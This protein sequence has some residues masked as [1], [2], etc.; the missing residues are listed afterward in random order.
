LRWLFNDRPLQWSALTQRSAEANA[1]HTAKNHD[2]VAPP[3]RPR[4]FRPHAINRLKEARMDL[5]RVA[6]AIVAILCLLCTPAIAQEARGTVQGRVLDS[7]G[8]AVPGATVEVVNV[9]TGVVTAT[10]TNGEGSYRV[11]FLIPGKYRVTVSLTGF[12][13]FLSEDFTV[14]VSDVLTV[15]AAL[16]V[17]AITD[18]VT[19]TASTVTVDRATAEL[20]QVVDARRIE[21]LPIRE[22]S[23]VE[24]VVLAP[25]VTVTT[26]LRSRKAAFNNGLSQFSTDGVGE[27]KN[28]FTIDGVSNVA[29]DRVAYS[30]PSASVEEFKIHTSSYDA[31]I[32]NT[33][34]SVVNLVTKS[35]TNTLR[36]QAYEWFRGAALD[37]E[38]FFDKRAGRPKRDYNDNRFGG[39]IGGPIRSNR[40]FYFG[41][42]EGNVWQGPQPQILTVPTAKMR[43]GDFSDLLALGPQYQLY[44][45]FTTKPHP[46]QAG[47]FI[48]DPFV[49][50]MIP[51]SLI[52]PVAKKI[53]EFFPLPNQPGLSDGQQNF[54]NPTAVA[55]ETYYTATGRVDHNISAK[56]RI[57]GRFSWD[58]WEEEKDDRFDNVAT[59]IFLNRKNR[60]LGLD[61][62]YTFRNNLLLNVRGG[63]TRQLFPERRR[64]QG[65]DL[66]SLGF[67]PQLLSLVP[68]GLSA[69]PFINF[70]N[71][72]DFGV[73]ESG[74]G[75]FTTDVYS[76]TG[77]LMW[78]LG[79]HSTKFGTEYR[80]YIED[81]SRF[82]NAVS[83]QLNFSTTWV[84]GPL[85]NSAAAPFGQDFASFLLGLPT[86]GTMSRAA[87]YTEKSSVLS[88]YAHDDWRV[89][90]NLTLNLGVRWEIEQPLTESQGRYVS[91]FDASAPLPIAG[92]AESNYARNPIAEV[93]V[94]QFHVRGG[95]LYP[96]T[97]GPTGAW[98]RNL[99]NI[100]PR[101]G[102]AWLA[103]PKTSVRGG[104]GLFY[105][106]LGTN[107][108]TVNQTGYSR[109]TAL[110]A[111]LDNGQTFVATLANP[112]PNGLLEPVGS[113]L[114]L[115]TNVGQGALFPYVGEVKN[116]RNHRLSIGVQRELPWQFLVEAT[117]VRA[118]GE[119]L[120]VLRQLN[121]IPRQYLSTSPVRDDV[122]NNRLT[123]QV[124]NPF[125]GLLPG[126]NLN[127]ANVARSQLLRPF[128]QFTSVQG[129]ETNGKSDYNSLQTRVERRMANG[130]TVQ[131]AYAWSR[132][133]IETG[134]LNDSDTTLERVISN[135][136]REHTFSTSGLVEMPFGRG[137][138]YGRGWSRLTDSL[139]GGWQVGFIFKAQSGAPLGF[140]NFLFAEG[141][142]VKDILAANPTV[143]Q[144]FN[145]AAFNRVSA[146]Q[147]V[148][149]VRTQ[150]SRFADV[151]GPGYALLDL[152]VLKNV[153][154][155]GNRRAQFRLEAYNVTN[156]VNLRDPNTGVT[157]NALG[158]ITLM[159]G[160]PRQLQIA[161]RLTF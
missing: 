134:Y 98:E 126:T 83:P 94:D 121:A 23:P 72:Q 116:P 29:N 129:L 32:G 92:T 120:P 26:D 1:F 19:V 113:G 136:D 8:A 45:P 158:T 9:A 36:G 150:P 153:S 25:G 43:A 56:H 75:Y 69:F 27:K 52:D 160:L 105:D 125:A 3:A 107:R 108:I 39:A 159:N 102:F 38:I 64:S 95:L 156:R 37:A 118:L 123:A 47:R 55:F 73:S 21:E 132:T 49:G 66:S 130:F 13:R 11:P 100:M 138:R 28:D 48:R 90:N 46:T 115:M 110:S 76:A 22:G 101:A 61:D 109:D 6:A 84:R 99:T 141:K 117:Y 97:G 24:L 42:F 70:D 79:R 60:I 161:V 14:H 143:D 4:W 10:T 59:G 35:G 151:R 18:E 74:D 44:N 145:V 34:G 86:G 152:S 88:L 122:T 119:H 12:G 71:F 139:L 67:S 87:A 5:R 16:K 112:F 63:F 62:A 91:G 85:D 131:V 148:S 68:K 54:T 17:G 133:M 140:G 106:Q 15:D 20:G 96:D 80:Y 40:T 144:W 51:A 31:A 77:T 57:Y 127:A 124:P 111:S 147:L 58:F 104:Y 135:F 103:T 89:R 155:G 65:F 78:L 146:Q 137:R 33:M 82:S 30:P 81:A 7:S 2:T 128:P 154:L 93:P 50:N 114:G 142:G 53:M 41:N 157:N 149:N